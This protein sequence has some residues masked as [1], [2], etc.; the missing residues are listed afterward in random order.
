MANQAPVKP[1]F[2]VTRRGP[3]PNRSV[4]LPIA[5]AACS[6]GTAFMSAAT[7]AGNDASEAVALA[8]GSLEFL[9]FI[10]RDI[11]AAVNG[12]PAVPVPTYAELSIGAAP[13]LPLETA[14]S[15]GLEGSLEDADEYEAEGSAFISSGN[16]GGRDWA[17]TEAIGTR[18]SFYAGTTCKAI[19]GQRAEYALAEWITPQVT[20]NL[21]A[22]FN[23]IYGD[24]L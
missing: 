9:G 16:G 20:G 2:M 13:S 3:R 15:A 12:V 24:N 4:S 5:L 11:L 14:F 21:R 17:G 6:A 19:T 1:L 23:R 18:A 8:D 22:R 10:T 7:P